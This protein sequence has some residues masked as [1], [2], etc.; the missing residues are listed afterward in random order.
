M[1][2]CVVIERFGLSRARIEWL[3]EELKE[4]EPVSNT[5]RSCSLAP[6]TQVN[7]IVFFCLFVFFFSQFEYICMEVL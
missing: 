2:D 3:V 1:A 5:A 7:R 4:E 6:E